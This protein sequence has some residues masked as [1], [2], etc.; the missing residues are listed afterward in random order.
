M[1]VAGAND[2]A[3]DLFDFGDE[4]GPGYQAKLQH[5]LGVHFCEANN[6]LYVTDTYNHK[7]KVMAPKQGCEEIG[8]VSETPLL[9]WIGDAHDARVR[10]G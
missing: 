6:T 2:D 9:N 10:D 7:I 8:L 4:E 3:L 1:N 5:P